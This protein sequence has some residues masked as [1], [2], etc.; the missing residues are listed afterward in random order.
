MHQLKLTELHYHPLVPD[1]LDNSDFEFIELK[2]TGQALDISGVRFTEG[3]SYTFPQ[4][5]MLDAGGF[6]VLASGKESFRSRYGF[7]PFGEYTGALDN[8]GERVVMLSAQSD[9][10]ISVTYADE[11]PWPGEADGGGFSLV[12]KEIDPTGDPNDPSYWRLSYKLNGSPG[13]DDVVTQIADPQTSSTPAEF[14]LHQNF[15]NP[16]NSTTIIGYSVPSLLG[17]DLVSTPS[18]NGQLPVASKISLKVY[19]LLGQEVATLFEGIRQPGN[20]EVAFDGSGLASGVYFYRL[21]AGS[22]VATNKLVLL[23]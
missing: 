15:P 13:S 3:I 8:G 22:F 1:T 11:S 5:T 10:L 2:N 18:R 12:S 19:N 16:F 4:N 7:S 14:V 20:Y 21:S 17:R 9:T 23:K 6:V